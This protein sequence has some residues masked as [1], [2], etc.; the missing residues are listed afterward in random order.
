MKSIEEQK[1]ILTEQIEKGN[2]FAWNDG[3]GGLYEAISNQQTAA[4]YEEAEKEL[5]DE[6]YSE[7]D[8]RYWPNWSKVDLYKKQLNDSYSQESRH[9]WIYDLKEYL[10]EL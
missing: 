10:E 4:T 3:D 1:R 2:L 9:T 8:M 5:A 7:K 6:L